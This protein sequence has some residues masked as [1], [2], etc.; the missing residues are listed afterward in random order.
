MSWKSV[1]VVCAASSVDDASL[2]RRW[3]GLHHEADFLC[4]TA[5]HRKRLFWRRSDY[6]DVTMRINCHRWQ[7]RERCGNRARS[8]G[9]W[10]GKFVTI[11]T[12][13]LPAVSA[14]DLPASAIDIFLHIHC[15]QEGDAYGLRGATP[16]HFFNVNASLRHLIERVIVSWA[17]SSENLISI[18]TYGIP[19]R[20]ACILFIN[21]N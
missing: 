19:F 8:G 17:V 2:C 13:L 1:C 20:K 15:K 4:P 16:C 18:L 9:Q 3:A 21:F 14:R 7:S 5:M 12:C 10:T 11:I 6:D